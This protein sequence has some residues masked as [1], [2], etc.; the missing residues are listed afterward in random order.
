[1][2]LYAESNECHITGLMN[3]AQLQRFVNNQRIINGELTILRY[4]NS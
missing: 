1:M 3:F 2:K 4:K